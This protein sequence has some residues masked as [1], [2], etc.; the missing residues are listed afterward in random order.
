MPR[1]CD[2]LLLLNKFQVLDDVTYAFLNDRFGI[3][4]QVEKRVDRFL[5]RGLCSSITGRRATTT[6][7]WHFT[8]RMHTESFSSIDHCVDSGRREYATIAPGKQR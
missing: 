7:D 6:P 8:I 4:G 1:G 2:R 3:T 5:S